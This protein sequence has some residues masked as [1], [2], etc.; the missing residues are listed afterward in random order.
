MDTW[1]KR[2]HNDL[3]RIT[4]FEIQSKGQLN[5]K[6]LKDFSP[7]NPSSVYSLYIGDF[8]E[9]LTPMTAVCI[10]R[11]GNLESIHL[12][13]RYTGTIS[14]SLLNSWISAAPNLKRLN[15]RQFQM[16]CP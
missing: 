12:S 5:V 7:E 14:P 6:C 15:I 4:S 2:A 13:L 8:Q 3:Q 10:A 16:Q 9:S 11:M 1:I